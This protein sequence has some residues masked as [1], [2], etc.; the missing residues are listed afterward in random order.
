[1]CIRNHR[2]MFVK[3]ATIWYEGKPLPREA[4]AVGL[5][6]AIPWLGRLGLSKVLIELDCK[7]V[8]DSIFYRNSNQAEFGSI[9]SECRSLLKHYSNFKISFVRRQ[10]NF[11]ARMLARASRLNARHQEF[12]LIPSCIET[13]VRNEII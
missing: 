12:N 4:E 13:I 10:T 1:M 3:A 2:G 11:V 8:I 7:L 6:D 5:R 9:I